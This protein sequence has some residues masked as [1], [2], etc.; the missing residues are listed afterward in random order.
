MKQG[1]LFQIVYFLLEVG[2]TTAPELAKKFEV[3]IR[4]IYRDLDMI[5]EAGIPVYATQGKGGGISLL[6]DYVLDK[7]ILSDQEKE[8]ILMSLQSITATGDTK[9]EELLSKL[10]ALFK[11]RSTN[12][13]EV[14]F[15]DWI[16]RNPEQ[17]IFDTVKDAIFNSNRIAISYFGSNGFFT[18]RTIEPL[19]LVFKS[20]DWYLYAFCLLRKDYRFFKLTRIKEMKACQIHLQEMSL[21]TQSRRL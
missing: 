4:T 13:I 8:K 18:E 14:D 17:N 2:K 20:K 6:P 10:G 1:R 11:T 7:A 3:S 21:N 19:K 16:H 5:S 9:A 15:S 12:W